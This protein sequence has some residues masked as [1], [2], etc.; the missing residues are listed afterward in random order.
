[1]SFSQFSTLYEIRRLLHRETE[2]HSVHSIGTANSVGVVRYLIEQ[3]VLDFRKSCRNGAGGKEELPL[4]LQEESLYGAKGWKFLDLLN[5][6][7]MDF[8]EALRMLEGDAQSRLRK[9]G[10]IEAYGNIGDAASTYEFLMDRLEDW[11]AIAEEYPDPEH[12]KVNIDLGWDKLNEY[13]T[14]LDETPAYYASAVMNPASRWN[15]FENIW[16][17]KT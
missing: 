17:D 9:G 14:K 15:Y 7:L 13:Y 12:F 2:G 16:T 6:V 8:E 10:R 3:V 4:C 11:K 5:E 1:M